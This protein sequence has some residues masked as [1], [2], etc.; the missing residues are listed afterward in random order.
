[1]KKENNLIQH[2]WIVPFLITLVLLS[3]HVLSIKRLLV[4]NTTL[5]LLCILIISP[6]SLGLKKIKFGNFEAEL[7]AN[8]VKEIANETSKVK[9]DIK[10]DFELNIRENII[11][12]IYKLSEQDYIMALVK[13]RIELE[14]ISNKIC[15]KLNQY[16]NIKNISLRQKI[17]I[18][19]KNKIIDKRIANLLIKVIS[20]CNKAIHCEEIEKEDALIV[21]DNGTWLLSLLFN[22]IQSEKPVDSKI[23]KREELDN[24]YSQ[25]YIVK[26]I[27]PYLNDSKKNTYIMTQDE[28]SEFLDYYSEYA[29]FI[30]EVRPQN[31]TD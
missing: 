24:Y 31:N 23:I 11:D 14:N 3:V 9:N 8:E 1:M 16:E 17:D 27:I 20:I 30:I 15:N 22:S 6:L 25:K 13:L 19:F 12:D 5:I 2:I 28:L 18:L 4:D 29:E 10:Q 26:T 21:L 7:M